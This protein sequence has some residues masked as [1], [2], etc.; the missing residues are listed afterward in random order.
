MAH[1]PP[2]PFQA[3]LKKME[4]GDA[5]MVALGKDLV[6]DANRCIKHTYR[7]WTD[8]MRTINADWDFDLVRPAFGFR[9]SV[10]F[11]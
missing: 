4:R 2:Q 6:A 3:A 10:V 1:Y 7:G 11:G 5:K 9:I 8:N